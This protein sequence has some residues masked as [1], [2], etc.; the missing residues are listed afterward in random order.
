MKKLNRFG[1]AE[2][3]HP[4]TPSLSKRAH[5]AK[6]FR[7][8]SVALLV[9]GGLASQSYAEVIVTATGTIQTSDGTAFSLGE[10]VTVTF[11]LAEGI[12]AP[13]A[14]NT[15]DYARW[16]VSAGT[17]SDPSWGYP[18]G[19]ALFSDISV[20]G[21]TGSYDSG[22]ADHSNVIES[23]Y[24]V[25][26]NGRVRDLAIYLGV[27]EHA[28]SGFGLVRGGEDISWI[29]FAV[30]PASF[31]PTSLAGDASVTP[32]SLFPNGTYDTT[33]ADLSQI[34]FYT[35]QGWN[36]SYD[37]SVDSFTISSGASEVS[38][39]PEPS[40]ALCLAGL[41]ASSAFLRRREAV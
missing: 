17:G 19:T 36:N 27:Y 41:I 14:T 38:A 37:M 18:T 20:S 10:S 2:I 7:R 21:A 8:L 6:P 12:G 39:V 4:E 1:S 15:T 11:T 30:K 31:L 3:S 28:E 26:P 25:L 13:N 35:G 24:K 5:G 9:F 22:S 40:G 23:G 33:G 16:E 34:Y 32:E 29:D